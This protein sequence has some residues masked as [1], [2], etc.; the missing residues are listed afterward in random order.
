MQEL[1]L[2]KT[3]Y[4]NGD[5]FFGTLDP[6]SIKKQGFGEL[7]LQDGSIHLGEFREDKI[8]GMTKIHHQNGKQY[9]G[10]MIDGTKNGVGILKIGNKIFKGEF[11]HGKRTGFGVFQ[12]LGNSGGV[13]SRSKNFKLADASQWLDQSKTNLGIGRNI[14]HLANEAPHSIYDK[15]NIYQH[16][17]TALMNLPGVEIRKGYF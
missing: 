16:G 14:A 17:T 12:D 13:S 11:M 15:T 8:N 10:N 4:P 6:Q 7:R 2:K 1:E 3:Q 9:I 5:V